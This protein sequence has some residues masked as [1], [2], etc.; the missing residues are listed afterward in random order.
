MHEVFLGLLMML[1]PLVDVQVEVIHRADLPDFDPCE[2]ARQIAEQGPCLRPEDCGAFE[3]WMRLF[4]EPRTEWLE[5]QLV[6]RHDRPLA[7]P[8]PARTEGRLSPHG[9][10]GS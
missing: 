8:C 2:S 5:P 10:S 1:A 9:G 3:S 6:E 7:F 4:G